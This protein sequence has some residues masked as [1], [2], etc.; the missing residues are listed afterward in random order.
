MRVGGRKRYEK[1]KKTQVLFWRQ[2]LCFVS[3]FF[4]SPPIVRVPFWYLFLDLDFPFLVHHQ[5]VFSY[6]VEPRK[7]KTCLG[8]GVG[9]NFPIFFLLF[10]YPGH[11]FFSMGDNSSGDDPFM[12]QG[13]PDTAFREDD[14]HEQRPFL[15][16]SGQPG[17]GLTESHDLSI[18]GAPTFMSA[19]SAATATTT[20]TLPATSPNRLGDGG[21]WL[22]L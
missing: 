15:S 12:L 21:P 7:K 18:S 16:F 2:N 9:R 14:Y 5:G 11:F 19:G 22:H 3:F 1:K 20:L 4:P 13:G 6:F 10:S 8:R 17:H